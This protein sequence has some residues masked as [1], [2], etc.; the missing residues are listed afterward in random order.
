[1]VSADQAFRAP[2]AEIVAHRLTNAR[3]RLLLPDPR[4]AHPP[5]R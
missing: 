2:P 5:S 1:M 4:H 3:R